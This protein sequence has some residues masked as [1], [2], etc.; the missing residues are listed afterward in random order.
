MAKNEIGLDGIAFA[1]FSSED[2]SYLE[3]LFKAF[4]FSKM[5]TQKEKKVDLFQQGEI[6]F[7]VNRNKTNFSS[8]FHKSHGP[9]LS[10]MGWYSLNPKKTYDLAV[11]RGAKGVTV[12]VEQ[13]LCGNDSPSYVLEGIGGSLIYLVD[14]KEKNYFEKLNFTKNEEKV[15][16]LGFLNIDHLTNNI[17]E[18]TLDEWS[19][20]YKKI[21]EFTEI[22]Y[23]DI[24]G[25]Q[26]GLKSF[27][28]KSPCEK[29]CIPINEGTEKKSQINEY[30]EEYNGPGVQHIALTTD[31]IVK[32]VKSLGK[33]FVETLDIDEEYYQEVFKRVPGVTE[34]HKDLEQL[35]ILVDGDDEGYLLQIFTKNIIGPIFFEI[36]QRKNHHSFG[37]GNFSALFK[38]I[39]RD[40]KKRGFLD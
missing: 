35:N 29:F 22:R 14:S 12:D 23:F 16:S 7:L 32:T 38:S 10:S 27:A 18:G 36:I 4:G 6:N 26:T 21:F 24:R 8:E 11:S 9:C 5:M 13:Q 31:D 30:L 17:Y 34:N 1:E 37:E 19:D 3:K 39:E 25:A 33:T 28:L 2:P 15:P 20:F 40:Q